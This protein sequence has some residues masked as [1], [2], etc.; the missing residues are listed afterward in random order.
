MEDNNLSYEEA[1]QALKDKLGAKRVA[2]IEPDED[3]LAHSDGMLM[4][5]DKSTLLVNDYSEFDAEYHDSVLGE[6]Q[7]S[8]PDVRIIEVPVAYGENKPGE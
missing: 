4:W 7:E 6:L 3:V 8:F 5:L 1:K 2:I